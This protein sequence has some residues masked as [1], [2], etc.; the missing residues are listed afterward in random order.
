MNGR[1]DELDSLRG[2]AA[3]SVV[4]FHILLVM[5]NVYF[6]QIVNNTPLHIVWSGH[7]AVI[8][9]FV[10]SG[11][12]LSLP[13]HKNIAPKYKD[14]IIK[15]VCR[16]YIP[17]VVSIFL[18]IFCMFIFFRIDIPEIGGWLNISENSFPF[19]SLFNHV[20]LIDQFNTYHFNIVVWSLVHEMRIS[21]IF[22]VIMYFIVKHEWKKIL[23]IAI[24]CSLL[25]FLVYYF[26][27]R[28]FQYDIMENTTSYF[29]TLHYIAFFILGSLLSLHQQSIRIAYNQLTRGYKIIS[30]VIGVLMYT[31]AWWFFHKI[32]FFHLVIMN[33]WAIAVGASIFIIFSLNS[34]TIKRILLIKPILFIGK[35]SYSLYLY[36]VIVLLSLLNIFYGKLSIG[37]IL[38]GAFV[39]SF[40]IA[41]VMYY[42]IEIPSITFGRIFISKKK[43]VLENNLKAKQ[44]I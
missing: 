19:R 15:R 9:F 28:I 16:I 12:V 30:M 27:L 14:Y 40:M 23:L 17:Y 6:I 26:S 2:L 11:Y 10:L 31:Y 13:Y 34:K 3:A 18:A 32:P 8:L 1:Y 24:S 5:P 33:D 39:I 36:H 42:I 38:F 44:L 41:T 35:I 29:A 43:S 22:P 4:I 25:Y 21:I 7:E 37:T 20:I